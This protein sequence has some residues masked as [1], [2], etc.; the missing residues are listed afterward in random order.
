M[1]KYLGFIFIIVCITSCT[2]QKITSDKVFSNAQ[3]LYQVKEE[4]SGSKKG[5]LEMPSY[6]I[7]LEYEPQQ[8]KLN[9]T[10]ANKVEKIFPKLVYPEEYKLYASFGAATEGTQI[11]SLSTVFKRAQDLKTRYGKR[12]KEIKIV[13]LKN[14]KPDCVYLRLLG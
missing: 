14:Q 5:A 2:G 7:D 13:Y 12:V 6:F 8:N 11:A 1:K 9:Q 10:Q 3:I 4:N